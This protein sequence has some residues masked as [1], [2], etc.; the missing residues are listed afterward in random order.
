VYLIDTNIISEARKQSRAHPG[1]IDF[2]RQATIAG[3]PLY[4][5]VITV[6]E[7]RRGV[8]LIRH[9]GDA[10]QAALLGQWLETLLE[11]YAGSI[12]GFDSDAAQVWGRLRVPHAEHELDQGASRRH[13]FLPPGNHRRHRRPPGESF[14]AGVSTAHCANRRR[15]PW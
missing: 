5:S 4:L 7:L 10:P 6:G 15:G 3:T 13:R 12:L 9:R 8:E 11:Q 1:V 2:F 14:S